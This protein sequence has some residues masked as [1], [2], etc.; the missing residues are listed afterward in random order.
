VP[1]GTLV[2]ARILQANKTSQGVRQTF[3]PHDVGHWVTHAL[4]HCQHELA[5]SR[6]VPR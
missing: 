2:G 6:T 4:E 1:S 5:I 3:A